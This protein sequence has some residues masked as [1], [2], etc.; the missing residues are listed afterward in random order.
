MKR[1]VG[2]G[3]IFF[4]AKDAPALRAWYA[5]HLGIEVGSWGG[6]IFP[7]TE[8]EGV[9]P[10]GMT[11]W[12]PFEAHHEKFARAASP[13]IINYVVDDLAA[14]VEALREEGCEVS[15]EVERSEFG[16]FAWVM[17]PEGHLV[18]LWEPA[19]EG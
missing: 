4:K 7:W 14:L 12:T 2:V 16:A 17:D 1:V 10:G 5:K 18:E 15:P 6:A 13:F 11:V 19:R 9:A 8:G 3:G